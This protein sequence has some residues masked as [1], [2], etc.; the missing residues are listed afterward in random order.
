MFWAADTGFRFPRF[1]RRGSRPK[2]K[3]PEGWHLCRKSF[4]HIFK[5]R[6]ERHLFPTK[7]PNEKKALR[8][9]AKTPPR[10]EGGDIF[11]TKSL[12]AKI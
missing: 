9:P 12:L 2:E 4:T 3:I 10:C 1:R 6:Q 8:T 5:L 7:P 11:S